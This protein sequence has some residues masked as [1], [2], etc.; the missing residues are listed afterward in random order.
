M[1]SDVWSTDFCASPHVLREFRFC[2]QP[3]RSPSRGAAN[4]L[5]HGK[6]RGQPREIIHLI[7]PRR[8]TDA[9]LFENKPVLVQ[10]YFRKIRQ[11][12]QIVHL[13]MKSI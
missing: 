8:S 13:H 7:G 3:V 1:V 4:A 9:S 11:S 10:P 12:G 5:Y 6:P 2:V